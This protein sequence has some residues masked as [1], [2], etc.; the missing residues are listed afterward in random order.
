MNPTPRQDTEAR[1]ALQQLDAAARQIEEARNA[2]S[3]GA[4]ARV[5][6]LREL[7]ALGWS[8][9][10]IGAELGISR[11]QVHRLLRSSPSG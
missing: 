6:A 3:A 8:D 7:K 4:Q 1:R 2:M 10:R 9:I 5:D 11:Q